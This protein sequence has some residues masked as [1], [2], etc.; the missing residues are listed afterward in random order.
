MTVISTSG[1]DADG[2]EHDRPKR[3]D[4]ETETV[5][6]ARCNVVSTAAEAPHDDTLEAGM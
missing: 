2:G 3:P 5:L 6:V 1:G 4:N